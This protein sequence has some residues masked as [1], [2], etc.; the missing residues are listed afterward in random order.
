MP[1]LLNAMSTRPYVSLTRSNS[2]ET[3]PSSAT[4]HPK[5][6]PPTSSAA[7]RP[8]AS[9]TSTAMTRAPSAPKRL[10]VARPMP[11]PAPV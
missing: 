5:K 4:L 10:A 9:S 8:V 1:A 7:A 2:S 11:L 3:S 6:A